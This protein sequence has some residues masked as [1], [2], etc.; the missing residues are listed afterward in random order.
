MEGIGTIIVI[1]LLAAIAVP[2]IIMF[3]VGKAI[4]DYSAKKTAQEIV[5][6]L[7]L[8]QEVKAANMETIKTIQFDAIARIFIKEAEKAEERKAD[9]TDAADVK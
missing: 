2:L 9:R 8:R 4:I 5:K 6:Q 7:N 3:F 1:L